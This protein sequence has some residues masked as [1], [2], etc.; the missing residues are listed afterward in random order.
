MKNMHRTEN[1]MFRMTPALKKRLDW[2]AEQEGISLN[3]WLNRAVEPLT[4][5]AMTKLLRRKTRAA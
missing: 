1:V 5:D 4:M 3:E 2:I